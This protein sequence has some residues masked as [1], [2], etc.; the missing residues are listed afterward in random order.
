M[1]RCVDQSCLHAEMM[2]RLSLSMM[3]QQMPAGTIADAYAEAHPDIVLFIKKTE[4]TVPVSMPVLPHASGRYF[5]VVDS[6]D[7]LDTE[8]LARLMKNSQ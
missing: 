7:W 5:K 4:V 3:D 1:A 2:H 8:C 6:D